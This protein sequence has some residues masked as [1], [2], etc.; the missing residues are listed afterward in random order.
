MRDRTKE[1]VKDGFLSLVNN[2]AAIRGAKA[3]PLWLT[4]VMFVLSVL[5]PVVPIFVSNITTK[6]DSF[7]NSYPYGL[8]RYFT[9]V[10][11]DIEDIAIRSIGDIV[12]KIVVIAGNLQLYYQFLYLVKRDCSREFSGIEPCETMFMILRDTF[13][14]NTNDFYL[15]DRLNMRSVYLEM[16]KVL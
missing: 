5:L 13:D 3:G 10:A 9:Q 11:M 8:E 14:I 15:L 6:G 2:A 7:L 16:P 12:P 4:I 1:I